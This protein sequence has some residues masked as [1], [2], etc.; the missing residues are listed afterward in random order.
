MSCKNLKQK[1]WRKWNDMV[2]GHRMRSPLAL[3][4]SGNCGRRA[5]SASIAHSNFS[6]SCSK[7][8]EKDSLPGS[9]LMCGPR[10]RSVETISSQEA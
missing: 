3:A 7:R 10:V 8:F 1:E 2:A 5:P 6:H 4:N 9:S